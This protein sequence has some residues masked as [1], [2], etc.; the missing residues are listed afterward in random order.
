MRID[1]IR[2]GLNIEVSLPSF[3]MTRERFSIRSYTQVPIVIIE[4]LFGREE[5][6]LQLLEIVFKAIADMNF[7][8]GS[9]PSSIVP[10]EGRSETGAASFACVQTFERRRAYTA[11]AR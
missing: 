3:P 1:C 4:I 5:M 8:L 2:G 9:L 6:I 11:M 7:A 10:L